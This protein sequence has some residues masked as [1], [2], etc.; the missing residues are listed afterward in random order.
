MRDCEGRDRAVSV[1]RERAFWPP[2]RPGFQWS[3][4]TAKPGTTIGYLRADRFDDGSDVLA[5][6][7]MADLA[8]TSGL[9]IDIRN[10][11]G[12]N[13]SAMRLA[14]Y[15][16]QGESPAVVLLARP[17]LQALGR[18]VTKADLDKAPPVRRAYTGKA[19]QSAMVAN[20]GG[21]AFYS[22]DLGAKRY[23]KPVVVLIG[24]DTGSAAEGFGWYMRMRTDARLIGRPSAGALLDG[25]TFPLAGGWSLVV[26][27]SGVWTPDGR[28]LGDQAVQPHERVEW[29]RADLCHGRDPDMARAL[30]TLF[31]SLSPSA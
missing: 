23:A 11:S 26:P 30:E 9:I 8:D 31:G 27:V 29:T 16:G 22:E 5:D 18:P 6:Q 21:A 13:M 25:Q 12:G 20:R 19:V 4:V 14:S 24:P 15:F 10:N 1:R 17:Y 2:A 3:R 28:N 7:A